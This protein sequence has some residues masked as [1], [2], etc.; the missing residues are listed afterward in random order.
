MIP[1]DRFHRAIRAAIAGARIR[2]RADERHAPEA[3]REAET[4]VA[5]AIER[6]RKDLATAPPERPRQKAHLHLEGSKP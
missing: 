3:Q 5:E 2:Y 1:F 4:A 6:V